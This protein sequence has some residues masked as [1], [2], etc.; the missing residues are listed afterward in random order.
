MNRYIRL[1]LSS[2]KISI[3]NQMELRG[4]FFSNL[5]GSLGNFLVNILFFEIIY[6]HVE[7]IAGWTRYQAFLLLGIFNTFMALVNMIIRPSITTVQGLVERGGLDG[8]LVKPFNSQLLISFISFNINAI[9]DLLFGAILIGFSLNGLSIL[10][11]FLQWTMAIL[12]LIAALVIFYALWYISITIVIWTTTLWSWEHVV[13]NIF[14]FGRYPAEIF[15]GIIKIIFM[16]LVPVII[17]ANFPTKMLLGE[18][19]WGMVGFTFLL[20]F[21]FLCI[22]ILF[23]KKALKSYQSASS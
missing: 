23:W 5:I 20:A 3:K 22:S 1:I 18:L 14:S 4:A 12:V 16:T 10:P 13:P 2:W 17:I 8:L 11:S 21:I 7:T 9:P 15:K 19:S 6:S